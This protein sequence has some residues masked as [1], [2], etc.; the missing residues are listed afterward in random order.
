MASCISVAGFSFFSRRPLIPHKPPL[1]VAHPSCTYRIQE[2]PSRGI[3]HAPF[4]ALSPFHSRPAI[5]GP[6]FRPGRKQQR[7]RRHRDTLRRTACTAVPPRATFPFPPAAL[8]RAAPIPHTGL[9]VPPPEP[10][11]LAKF[12]GDYSCVSASSAPGGRAAAE[13]DG[14]K[15][16]RCRRPYPPHPTAIPAPLA[17]VFQHGHTTLLFHGLQSSRPTH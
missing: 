10:P 4:V 13:P 11:A 8:R 7:R 6:T 9:P 5:G 12:G 15:V 2:G 16:V 3:P 1:N 17:C 14:W